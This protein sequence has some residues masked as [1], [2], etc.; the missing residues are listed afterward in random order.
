MSSNIVPFNE[1]NS[2]A[3]AVTKSG[4]FGLKNENQALTLM[5]IAQ[6]EG[7]HPIQAVQMY[8]VINGM[9]SLK[10]TEVQARFQR[11]GGKINWKETG[12]TK[13]VVELSIDGQTYT[14]EFSMDDAKR[15]GLADKDN[16]KKMP[17][18]MLMARCITMGVRALYPQCLNNMYSSDEVQDFS[19]TEFESVKDNTPFVEADIEAEV[20]DPKP[21]LKAEVAILKLK[22]RDLNL[23][24]GE[25]KG[26]AAHFDLQNNLDTIIALNS[27]EALL[28]EKIKEFEGAQA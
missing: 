23:S 27:D 15:M 8:S 7:I 4:M 13:A 17:K 2:M 14:S 18:Q 22:L 1:M 19:P 25:I 9:P 10:S 20:E 5:L 3:M 24:E 6:A 26:F 12:I 16:W 28:V 21:S 11:A